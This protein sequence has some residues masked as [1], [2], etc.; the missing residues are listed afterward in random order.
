MVYLST[1]KGHLGGFMIKD[2]ELRYAYGS[3]YHT[4]IIIIRFM[5]VNKTADTTCTCIPRN[6]HTY[7]LS[8]AQSTKFQ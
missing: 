6:N 1:V 7:N 8:L 4:A 2:M 3:K 5:I